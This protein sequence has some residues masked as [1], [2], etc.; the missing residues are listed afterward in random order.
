MSART[1]SGSLR[2]IPSDFHFRLSL[3]AYGSMISQTHGTLQ[4]GRWC[5]HYLL[6]SL[7]GGTA[8]H[9]T[10][11]WYCGGDLCLLWGERHMTFSLGALSDRSRF[12]EQDWISI[13][14]VVGAGS[15]CTTSAKQPRG[16]KETCLLASGKQIFSPVFKVS[17]SFSYFHFRQDLE[18]WTIATHA[19]HV[20]VTFVWAAFIG[21]KTGTCWLSSAWARRMPKSLT[22]KA[23][24]QCR[25]VRIN[26]EI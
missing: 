8:T 16:T 12:W 20:A 15:L 10:A 7:R 22:P 3:P 18:L 26:L 23:A 11:L 24:P 21:K 2:F 25:D 1:A 19:L 13:K 6:V 5:F 4:V 9:G 17:I 14:T